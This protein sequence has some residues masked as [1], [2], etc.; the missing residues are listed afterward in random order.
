MPPASTRLSL[1]TPSLLRHPIPIEWTTKKLQ[2]HLNIEISPRSL[3]RS[4]SL[5]TK[6]IWL[7]QI[8][9]L[10]MAYF[11]RGLLFKR[12]PSLASCLWRI[13]TP[14][15]GDSSLLIQTQ[16]FRGKLVQGVSI[17]QDLRSNYPLERVQVM[18]LAT[19]PR[20]WAWKLIRK[21]YRM[22]ALGLKQDTKVIKFLK[23]SSLD[24]WQ[25]LGQPNL[26]YHPTKERRDRS[27]SS[28]FRCQTRGQEP[29]RN[30]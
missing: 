29:S 9:M 10:S 3:S 22:I 6:G 17:S 16:P 4:R 18:P 26:F 2:D 11:H 27:K 21:W 15:R 24:K 7:A 13:T 19:I 5:T 8:T 30:R 25:I 28:T 1:H 14:R 12:R 20:L 23:N